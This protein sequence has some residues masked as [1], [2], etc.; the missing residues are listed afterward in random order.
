MKIK[1]R[2]ARSRRASSQRRPM[3]TARMKEEDTQTA[4]ILSL[5][6]QSRFVVGCMIAP[7]PYEGLIFP[8]EWIVRY[9]TCEVLR[10]TS[11][12]LGAARAAWRNG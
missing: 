2:L 6:V 12:G 5:D 10:S 3:T 1:E 8:S 9:Q 7:S 4:A 11:E